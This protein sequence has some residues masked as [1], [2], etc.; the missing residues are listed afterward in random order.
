MDFKLIFTLLFIVALQ[1]CNSKNEKPAMEKMSNGSY[2]LAEGNLRVGIDPELGGRI[3][4]VQIDGKELL[5]Q[6]R[7]GLLN[8]GSTLWPAPQSRWNWPPPAAIQ[9]G[10]YASKIQG[11]KLIL[12]SPT[13]TTFGFRAIKTFSFDK[14][15]SGLTIEYTFIN[16]ADS[17]QHVGPW[18]IS[19]VPA[20]GIV[21][22]PLGAEPANSSGNLAIEQ[23]GGIALL[24][25]DPNI[26]APPQKLYNNATEGWLAHVN[27]DQ[28]LFV[29]SFAKFP[30]KIWP[31]VREMWRCMSIKN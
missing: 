18:E 4:S 16:D 29:K 7:P 20:E 11:D 3:F 12:E 8:W 21:F 19:C 26:P 2:V 30:Q 24:R 22:F 28:V 10:K 23:V 5:L 1:G 15:K 9:L 13:D 17:A 14:E 25:Y 6:S 27:E 31:L